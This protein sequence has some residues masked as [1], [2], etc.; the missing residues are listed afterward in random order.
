MLSSIRN[1]AGAAGMAVLTLGL[2][3]L[4]R[5]VRAQ[6]SPASGSAEV[7]KQMVALD[8]EDSDT[9][10]AFTLLFRQVKVNY[11]LDKSLKG[12]TLTAHIKL[13]FRQAVDTLIR[14]SG[15]PVTLLIEN[16]VYSIVPQKPEDPPTAPE[17][18][19]ELEEEPAPTKAQV[20]A[21]IPIRN[22]N[23]IDFAAMFGGRIALYPASLAW[24]GVNPFAPGMFGNNNNGNSGGSTGA[25]YGS[26]TTLSGTRSGLAGIFLPPGITPEHLLA[27]DADTTALF[28]LIGGP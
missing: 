5:G 1:R 19:G 4:P 25:A 24:H 22:L 26:G 21:R 15:L 9:Y 6:G 3:G 17:P 14:A 8:F 16:S 2:L 10:A 11:T 28:A 7:E 18:T 23:S 20:L 27:W 12:S 13:P